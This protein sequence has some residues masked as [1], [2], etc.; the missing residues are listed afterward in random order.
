MSDA[1]DTT[2]TEP[3][4]PV[5][6]L[7]EYGPCIVTEQ[8]R[9]EYVGQLPYCPECLQELLAGQGLSTLEEITKKGS[10]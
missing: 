10:S 4:C 6:G 7:V 8:D 5:H 2:A 1:E 3:K 9:T